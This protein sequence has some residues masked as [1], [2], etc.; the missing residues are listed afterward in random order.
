MNIDITND[1]GTR[2]SLIRLEHETYGG[3]NAADKTDMALLLRIV[4]SLA[5]E[6]EELKNHTHSI[7]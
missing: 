3:D 4:V 2:E 1:E 6:I 5:Q 7:R